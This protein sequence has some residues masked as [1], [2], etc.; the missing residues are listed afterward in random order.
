M[1]PKLRVAFILLAIAGVSRD[2]GSKPTPIGGSRTGLQ[3]QRYVEAGRVTEPH[4][5]CFFRDA[6][7]HRVRSIGS[8]AEMPSENRAGELPR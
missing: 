8:W 5:P 7:P 3:V 6:K 2:G 1:T 4:P